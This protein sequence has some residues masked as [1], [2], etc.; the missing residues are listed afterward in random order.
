M[1]EEWSVR[2]NLFCKRDV[3]GV[4]HK[5]ELSLW[6]FMFARYN[7]FLS[8]FFLLNH[9]EICFLRCG[10]NIQKEKYCGVGRLIFHHHFALKLFGECILNETVWLFLAQLSF[11]F[12][13]GFLI[14]FEGQGGILIE[15]T[16]N[17]PWDFSASRI[18]ATNCY[19]MTA[20]GCDC[21][22]LS[23]ASPILR[24]PSR[25]R[26]NQPF[27]YSLQEEAQRKVLPR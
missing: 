21:S 9:G 1:E 3:L 25:S 26:N 19:T 15:V 13:F 4:I 27:P 17:K 10:T 24:N 20:A 22:R 8:F 6:G 18:Q 5:N 14:S 12:P 16:W 7:F 11:W 2:E 23:L